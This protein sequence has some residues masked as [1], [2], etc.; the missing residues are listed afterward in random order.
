MGQVEPPQ[1]NPDEKVTNT[2]GAWEKIEI[3][4]LA[5]TTYSLFQQTSVMWH[6]DNPNLL[7]ISASG[8]RLLHCSSW[9]QSC[10]HHHNASLIFTS[11]YLHFSATCPLAALRVLRQYSHMQLALTFYWGASRIRSESENVNTVYC[12]YCNTIQLVWIESW[13]PGLVHMWMELL[14]KW[15]I[16][17]FQLFFQ[18]SILNL[19]KPSD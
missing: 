19:K 5:V 6:V 11:E 1:L 8:H 18:N 9:K 7:T 16:C 2:S 17:Q 4:I 15:R 10:C 3:E 13:S 14:G 12:I